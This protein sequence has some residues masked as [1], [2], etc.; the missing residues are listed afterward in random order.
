MTLPLLP[1]PGQ[2]IR[3]IDTCSD[4][5]MT[6]AGCLDVSLGFTFVVQT[7]LRGSSNAAWHLDHSG[8]LPA[9][10]A[11][12]CLGRLSAL[13][14]LDLAGCLDVTDAGKACC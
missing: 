10:Q 7:C 14:Q 3:L 13:E 1:Q 5:E 12:G 2:A 6:R 8:H 4:V 9:V 11:L